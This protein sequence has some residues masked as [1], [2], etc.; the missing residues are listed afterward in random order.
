MEELTLQGNQTVLQGACHGNNPSSVIDGTVNITGIPTNVDANTTY[1]LT[2]TVEYTSGT[3]T[4]AGFQMVVLDDSNNAD[5]GSLTNA[6][7]GSTITPS[8]GRTYFEHSPAQNF[9]TGTTVSY[10][11]EWTA[12]SSP[13]GQDLTFYVASIIANGNGSP[14]LDKMKLLEFSSTLSAAVLPIAVDAIDQTDITCFGEDDGS[15]LLE[16]SGGT[17]PYTFDWDNGETTNPAVALLPGN[18]TVIIEDA[19]GQQ[20]TTSVNINE[21]QELVTDAVLQNLAC[22]GDFGGAIELSSVGGTGNYTYDWDDGFSGVSQG[23]LLA[24]NYT[25]TTTDDNNCE[26]VNTYTLSEPTPISV[27]NIIVTDQQCNDL[28]AIEISTTGGTGTLTSTWSNNFVGNN[29]TGLAAGDYQVTVADQNSCLIVE[30]FTVLPSNNLEYETNFTNPSCADA[31][32]GSINLIFDSPTDYTSINWSTG[33]N[34]PT[35]NNLDQGTYMVTIEDVD[36][37]S[38]TETFTLTDPVILELSAAVVGSIMCLGGSVDSVILSATG[39]NGPYNFTQTPEFGTMMATNGTMLDVPAGNYLYIVNDS[40]GCADSISLSLTEPEEISAIVNTSNTSNPGE[41]DGMASVTFSGGTPPYTVAGFG[42]LPDSIALFAN[43]GAGDY[44]VNLIDA[45]DCLF[46][47]SFIINDGVGCTLEGANIEIIQPE[48]PGDEPDITVNP[49]GGTP[50]YT[51]IIPTDNF[52]E[53]NYTL[54]ITDNDNCSVQETIGINYTDNESPTITNIEIDPVYL[55]EFGFPTAFESSFDHTDNCG[56]SEVD[57]NVL[58]TASCVFGQSDLTYSIEVIDLVGNVT[59]TLIPII[60]LDTFPPEVICQDDITISD[61][62][63]FE[64][65][66]PFATDNC[67]IASIESTNEVNLSNGVN[68]YEFLVIDNYGNS[69][70]CQTMVTVELDIVYDVNIQNV[71][72]FGFEDGAYEVSA[73]APLV[74]EYENSLLDNLPVGVYYFTVSDGDC[75]VTD[76]VVITQPTEIITETMVTQLSQAGAMDGAIDATIMGGAPPYEITWYDFFDIEVGSGP[77]VS[78]LPE[79]TYTALIVDANGCDAFVN[80]TSI[81]FESSL[82][83]AIFSNVSLYPNPVIN[84]L[85]IDADTALDNIKIYDAQGKFVKEINN[86]GSS[87]DMTVLNSGIYLMELSIKDKRAYRKL[88]KQ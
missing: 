54:I 41:F 70:T 6:G 78:G 32:N 8:G 7:S 65:D 66:T 4:R 24:G 2:V 64:I 36:F 71:S 13:D 17:G 80:E 76:S 11:V 34:T 48:C 10:D 59:D 39:G 53:G 27:S 49:I 43:L 68:V 79:G 1:D 18:N 15:A 23:G 31:D 57:I 58:G 75:S 82:E 88:I 22:A 77:S 73:N 87:I 26:T 30:T 55:D 44:T 63:N 16:I 85:F 83:D 14:S 28:G 12:P 40:N 21:P 42:T 33:D 29:N 61:C 9:G 74:V 56:D 50:P 38:Y 86:P 47:T 45:N 52:Y 67:G 46:T 19:A 84:E 35:I 5:F 62:L 25:I 81:S 20:F 51:F 72:C 37:C 3:P 60:V 69:A